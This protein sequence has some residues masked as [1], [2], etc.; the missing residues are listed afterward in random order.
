MTKTAFYGRLGY[1]I[2]RLY[3]YPIKA[4]SR[5][6]S[7]YGQKISAACSSDDLQET[8]AL[9]AS[10]YAFLEEGRHASLQYPANPNDVELKNGIP[11]PRRYWEVEGNEGGGIPEIFGSR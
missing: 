10:T 8:V 1:T 7:R 5:W 2:V 11:A 4:R 6:K 3:K 9:W